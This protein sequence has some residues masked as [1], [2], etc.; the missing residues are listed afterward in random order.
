MKKKRADLSTLPE[1]EFATNK[2]LF[3]A[4]NLSNNDDT[5]AGIDH[6]ALVGLCDYLNN[7]L[8]K[9]TVENFEARHQVTLIALPKTLEPLDKRLALLVRLENEW[10]MVAQDGTQLYFNPELLK[11]LKMQNGAYL[12]TVFN[13]NNMAVVIDQGK[14][15]S[16]GIWVRIVNAPP[17]TGLLYAM[18]LN[19]QYPAAGLAG[20]VNNT[21]MKQQCGGFLAI[22]NATAMRESVEKTALLF[23]N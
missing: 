15:N 13:D 9:L 12:L 6:P 1:P 2:P 19:S 20:Y 21:L 8:F 14:L 22:D 18:T 16:K 5:T 3:V 10:F 17:L 23:I 4:T 7:T 11:S